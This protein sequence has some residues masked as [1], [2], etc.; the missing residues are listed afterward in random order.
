GK[1][2]EARELK[3]R[4]ITLAQQ[5]NLNESAA[6]VRTDHALLEAV[7]GNVAQAGAEA[8]AGLKLARSGP[9]LQ[10]AALA[11]ALAG[12]ASGAQP[13]LVEVEKRYPTDTLVKA[14]WLPAARAALEINKNNPAKAIE[15]LQAAAP[16][17]LG[18]IPAG[19]GFWPNYLRGQAYLRA[20]QGK[21]ATSEF[22]NI[23]DHRGVDAVSSLYALSHLGLAR[24]AAL[25]GD[26]AKARKSYQDFL[27]LWKDADPDIPIYQ[28]A[29][30][31]YAK[32]K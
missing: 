12:D 30:A 26:T 13:L 31:E 5:H 17:E 20:K 16:Y 6:V 11:L 7:F 10:T 27:A 19:S 4:A 32:I 18:G 2:K 29:K 8:G 1:L 22:Q 28:Q 15:L 3:S 24:A 14:V 21:E 9:V 23:L 25:S